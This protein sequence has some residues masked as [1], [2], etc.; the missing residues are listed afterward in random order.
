MTEITQLNFGSASK[1][2]SDPFF[3]TNQEPISSARHAQ[4]VT[5]AAADLPQVT[6]SLLVTVTTAG[7]VT[8]I[9]ANDLDNNQIALPFAPGTYQVNIQ[10]RAITVIAAGIAV[11]AFWS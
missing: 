11:V 6:S 1:T 8:V 4:V 5:A 10:V 2:A 7:S 9:M 3:A